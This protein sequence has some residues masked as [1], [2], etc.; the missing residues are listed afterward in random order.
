M[1]FRSPSLPVAMML[2]ER[3]STENRSGTSEVSPS[4]PDRCGPL[5]ARICGEQGAQH[6]DQ[7]VGVAVDDAEDLDLRHGDRQSP[8]A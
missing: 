5:P 7:A 2:L 1:I 8:V 3:V 4:A 6:H